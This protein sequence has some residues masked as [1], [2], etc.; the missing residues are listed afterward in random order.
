MINV[1]N[2]VSLPQGHGDRW[3]DDETSSQ[4][5]PHIIVHQCQWKELSHGVCCP[6]SLFVPYCRNAL[7]MMMMLLLAIAHLPNP[8][9][10]YLFSLSFIFLTSYISPLPFHSLRFASLHFTLLHFT[11]LHFTLLSSPF[12]FLPFTYFLYFLYLILYLSPSFPFN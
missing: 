8:C 10:F 2:N 4:S 12:T 1:L 6:L 3:S 5:A 7:L 11:S 9:F